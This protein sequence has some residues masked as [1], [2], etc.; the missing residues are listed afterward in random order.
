MKLLVMTSCLAVLAIAQPAVPSGDFDITSNQIERA[1]AVVH[2]SGNATVKTAGLLIEADAVDFNEDTHRIVANGNVSV[3]VPA[4]HF[5]I[6]SNQIER[7][8]PV[9]HLS[10][11]VT[12]RIDA[13]MIEA[14]SAD[15]NEDTRKFIT[16][17]E[18]HVQM[19]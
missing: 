19:K 2:L 12:F 11:N 3:S 9:I 7:A 1:G 17:G 5:D 6:T 15:F 10:G 16:D 13:A 4:G 8:G 14:Q 18:L